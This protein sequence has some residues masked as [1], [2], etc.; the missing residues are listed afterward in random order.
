MPN[1]PK[2]PGDAVLSR[3]GTVKVN[4]QQVG[5]WWMW[6]DELRLYHFAFT[7]PQDEAA[8]TGVVGNI[9]R[10]LFKAK[11]AEYI[12]SAGKP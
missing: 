2:R 9:F 4:G 6:R 10:H 5:F 12:T 1:M 3:D 11:V 8:E 7:R